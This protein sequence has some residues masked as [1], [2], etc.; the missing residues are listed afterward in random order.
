MNWKF[1]QPIRQKHLRIVYRGSNELTLQ[2]WRTN[3]VLVKAAREIMSNADMQMMLQV[4][5]NEHPGHK[6][7]ALGVAPHASIALQR[8]GEG[9]TQCLAN[10]KAMAHLSKVPVALESTFEPEEIDTEK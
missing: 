5:A 2:E 6:V 4:L 7:L 3:D 8:Q 10:L 9:Y 1:W